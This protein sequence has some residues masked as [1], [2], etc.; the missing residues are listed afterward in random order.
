MKARKGDDAMWEA[1]KAEA[2]AFLAPDRADA[3]DADSK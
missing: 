2:A 3:K 1:V